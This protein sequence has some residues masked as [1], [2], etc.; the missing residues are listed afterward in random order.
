MEFGM[1]NRLG[2]P[3]RGNGW[4]HQVIATL[5]NCNWDRARYTFH[6]SEQISWAEPTAVAEIVVLEH[7]EAQ[8]FIQ[9]L[10]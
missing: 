8:S 4:A 7:S 6:R 3:N 9:I 5:N 10:F 2:E 1:M